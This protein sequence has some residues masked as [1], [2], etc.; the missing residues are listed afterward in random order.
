MLAPG[1]QA[2]EREP[3]HWVRTL[4][5]VLEEIARGSDAA[6]IYL[7]TLI[8]TI[9][10]EI[11]KTDP[12]VLLETRNLRA[13]LIYALSGGDSKVVRRLLGIGQLPP[14]EEAIAKGAL[15]YSEGKYSTAAGHLIG[16]DARSLDAGLASRVALTQAILIYKVDSKQAIALLDLARLL[17]T[18]TLIDEAATRREIVLLGSNQDFER[19]GFLSEQYMRKFGN[20]LYAGY[21]VKQFSIAAA[22]F[23]FSVEKERLERLKGVVENLQGE[24]RKLSLYLSLAENAIG[25]GN[26]VLA[27]FAAESGQSLSAPSSSNRSRAELYLAAAEVAS[28]NAERALI[29]LDTIPRSSLKPSDAA[30]RDVVLAVGREVEREPQVEAD[31][32]VQRILEVSTA[33][34]P[35]KGEATA[36]AGDDA[37]KSEKDEIEQS[38][39]KAIADADKILGEDKK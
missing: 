19:F 39:R 21:F 24:S 30:L 33:D 32:G 12:K 14:L 17:A 8:K 10:D 29:M 31:G 16:I 36:P 18:G 35:A 7:P 1:A 5:S 37:A 22:A 3:H 38:A 6:Q 11:E 34:L 15:A 4:E 9:A 28:V 25:L 13:V 27:K 2:L 26:V 23:D 20:S